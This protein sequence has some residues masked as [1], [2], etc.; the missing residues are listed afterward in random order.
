M[1]RLLT[2]LTLAAALA[3]SVTGCDL[4]GDFIISINVDS[5]QKISESDG[6]FN[7]IL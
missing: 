4:D 7:G 3:G 6:N 2:R 1:N 5:E